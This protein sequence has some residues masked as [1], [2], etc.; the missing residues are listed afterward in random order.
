MYKNILKLNYW[1]NFR[2]GSLEQTA[3]T[4]FVM[5]I[6]LLVIFLFI[7]IY[8]ERFKKGSYT[9][10]WKKLNSF[11]LTNFIISLFLLFFTYQNIIFFSAR[12]WFIFWGLGMIFW[13]KHILNEVK[14]IPEITKKRKEIENFK[15][16][17]P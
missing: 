8:L 7:T 17:I 11:A 16:Y 14:K 6:V 4:Y 3:Q 9:K 5:F 12:F 2:P 10:I 13:L 15:K 1:T